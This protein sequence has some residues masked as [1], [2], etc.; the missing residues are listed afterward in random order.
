[1]PCSKEE[2]LKRKIKIL[3]VTSSQVLKIIIPTKKNFL[4]NLF[5]FSLQS[6][7]ELA[8]VH[9]ARR[10]VA[11]LGMKYQQNFASDKVPRAHHLEGISWQISYT[12]RNASFSVNF[13][14][15]FHIYSPTPQSS[16][17]IFKN[18]PGNLSRLAVGHHQSCRMPISLCISGLRQCCCQ[19]LRSGPGSLFSLLTKKPQIQTLHRVLLHSSHPKAASQGNPWACR[20]NDSRSSLKVVVL[21]VQDQE[22][23]GI[24]FYL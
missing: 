3:K 12:K 5:I 11:L 1:M 21:E 18:S 14:S 8:A 10:T 20:L 24:N 15:L 17:Q 22:T 23:Q 7:Q 4:S 16:L 6:E 19:V 13:N 2:Q 9:H